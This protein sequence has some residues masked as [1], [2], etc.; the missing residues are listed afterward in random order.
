MVIGALIVSVCLIVLGFTKEIVEFVLPDEELA[1][2]P[3]IALAVLSIYALDFAINAGE[4]PL[5]SFEP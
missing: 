4:R 5:F 3:T 1:K 2:G